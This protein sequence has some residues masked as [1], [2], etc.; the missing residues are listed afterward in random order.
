MKKVFNRK[1][2]ILPLSYIERSSVEY[3][4]TFYT[5]VV[6]L[7]SVI[8]NE[9]MADVIAVFTDNVTEMN[10]YI[11]ECNQPNTKEYLAEY[12]NARRLW[13]GSRFFFKAYV[14]SDNEAEATMA[15]KCLDIYRR[16]AD[17]RFKRTNAADHL[18]H[19]V[20]SIKN[21]WSTA[22]I[23]GTFLEDWLPKVTQKSNAIAQAYA[24]HRGHI[25]SRVPYHELG[26]RVFEAFRALYYTLYAQ[27]INTGDLEL[28]KLFESIN[29]L[30][31]AYNTIIKG[32]QTRVYNKNHE[33]ETTDDTTLQGFFPG[34][35]TPVEE[36]DAV[37]ATEPSVAME[38]DADSTAVVLPDT[39]ATVDPETPVA[40]LG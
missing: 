4:S 34:V 35:N 10:A 20:T 39:A 19:L 29:D 37:S 40:T 26:G 22:E 31:Q 17:T 24:T 14:R 8:G 2:D 1:A 27:M 25:E 21:A 38:A 33:E 5:K 18:Q 13:T 11:D 12:E 23:Q 7:C 6:D 15:L 9:A 3:Y 28:S 30:I 32:H 36:S 16:I